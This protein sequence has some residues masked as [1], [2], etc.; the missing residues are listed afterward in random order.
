MFGNQSNS[1]HE[2]SAELLFPPPK[3]QI[4]RVVNWF[5]TVCLLFQAAIPLSY[6]L[7]KQPTNERF[8]WRMFSSVHMSDWNCQVREVVEENGQMI[9]RIVPI[10]SIL[11]ESSVRGMQ[12]GQLDIAAKFIRRWAQRPEVRQVT[13]E[14]QGI[15]PSGR[16]MAPLRLAV[17]SETRA[18]DQK[19]DP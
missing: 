4:Q 18:V 19:T 2:P 13:Y 3:K 6:Y 9:E 1:R 12:T 7:F 17:N 16:K 5:I 8:A 10:G 11:E 15:W 14:A